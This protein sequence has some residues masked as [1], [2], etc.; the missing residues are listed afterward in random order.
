MWL[1][2]KLQIWMWL[3]RNLTRGG[4]LKRGG[5]LPVRATG[6]VWLSHRVNPRLHVFDNARVSQFLCAPARN[7]AFF[8]MT[9]IGV[10]TAGR[11]RRI[12]F[13]HP[14]LANVQ[15]ALIVRYGI[16]VVGFGCSYAFSCVLNQPPTKKV[17]RLAYFCE[18]RELNRLAALC[19]IRRP[20]DLLLILFGTFSCCLEE[21]AFPLFFFLL[22]RFPLRPQSGDAAFRCFQQELRGHQCI[23]HVGLRPNPIQMP[24]LHYVADPF[25]TSLAKV[26]RGAFLILDVARVARPR[27]SY[28]PFIRIDLPNYQD[29]MANR[30][31]CW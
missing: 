12:L 3:R 22:L 28:K 5:F 13:E 14:S 9:V 19:L 24:L 30:T 4:R 8:N 20:L 17:L 16:A 7:N 23:L 11:G 10:R 31:Y 18:W 15:D 2:R 27:K 21:H 29:D 6:D 26:V 25:S 1:L